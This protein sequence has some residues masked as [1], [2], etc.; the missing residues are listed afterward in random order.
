MMRRLDSRKLAGVLLIL[1][2]ALILMGIITA[3]TQYPAD[4]GYSTARN[5]I[6]DLGT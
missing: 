3:E 5:E 4:R 2:G 1:A 6:S